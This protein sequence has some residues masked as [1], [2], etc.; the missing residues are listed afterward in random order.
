VALG[1]FI[2]SAGTVS[3][4][5]VFLITWV[6]NSAGAAGV[7]LF[8]RR[9]GRPAFATRLGRRLLKPEALARLGRIYQR[10]GTWGIFLSRFVPGVRAIVPLFA[11]VVGLGPVRALLPTIV[12]S[13][14]WYGALTYLIITF[15]GPIQDVVTLLDRLNIW[16]AVVTLVIG[17]TIGAVV[18][19]RR[20]R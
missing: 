11:G 6:S 8:A 1:A 4:I 16:T 9:F 5:S 13:G 7:Y 12:A 20:H 14:L 2:A 15:A 18:W 17:V 19:K 10:H 3:P